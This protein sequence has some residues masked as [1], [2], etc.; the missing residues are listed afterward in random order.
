MT[1]FPRPL[2]TFEATVPEGWEQLWIPATSVEK[3]DELIEPVWLSN[4][5]AHVMKRRIMD[6]GTIAAGVWQETMIALYTREG[7]AIRLPKYW[8][9]TVH[10]KIPPPKEIEVTVKLKADAAKT[11]ADCLNKL[12]VAWRADQREAA[13]N[14]AKEIESQLEQS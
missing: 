3:D 14:I 1:N 6:V 10:R 11:F 12:S 9:V 13:T 4:G 2:S 8:P 7:G 5:H